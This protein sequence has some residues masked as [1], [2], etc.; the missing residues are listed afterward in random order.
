MNA[1]EFLTRST[2]WIS[3]AFYTIGC[4]VFAFGSRRPKLDY[5][6]RLAFTAAVAALVGHYIS[7]F[8]FYHS[9]SHES[10]YVETARQTAEV[11]KVNWGGGIFINYALLVLWIADV[12][13]WWLAGPGSY[14]RRPLWILLTWHGFLVFILFNATVVFKDGITRWVGLLVCAIVSLSWL[15][16]I[17]KNGST[18]HSNT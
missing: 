15:I 7:A 14:R 10:A 1:G 13:W 6:T 4:L 3:I 8:H 16:I 9:W 18:Q 2:V 5:W 11:F 12:G 17:T